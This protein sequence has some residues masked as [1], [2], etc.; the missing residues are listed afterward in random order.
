MGK[1]KNKR[2][3]Y[4]VGITTFIIVIPLIV[5]LLLQ[6]GDKPFESLKSEDVE[7]IELLVNPANKITE[8]TKK[9]QINKIIN[10]LNKIVKNEVDSSWGSYNGQYIQYTIIKKNN[11]IIKI[12]VLSPFVTIDGIGYKLTN[13]VCEELNDL[14]NSIIDNNYIK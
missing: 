11:E 5:L 12:G 10:T 3:L 9:E 6:K 2:M 13:N 14:A 1:L 7:K 4:F 8:I